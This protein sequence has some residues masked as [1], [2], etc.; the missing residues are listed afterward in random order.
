MCVPWIVPEQPAIGLHEEPVT[1]ELLDL[2]GQS[3]IG[4]GQF[5]AS[6][7]IRLTFWWL[8]PLKVSN[9]EHTRLFHADFY[10]NI[11]A[12]AVIDEA[13]K[14]GGLPTATERDFAFQWNPIGVDEGPSGSQQRRD[15]AI[16]LCRF[17]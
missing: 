14:T 15:A 3:W 16:A 9:A 12:I 11:L 13:N 8:I 7:N 2:A 6:L 1:L 10:G 4:F 5:N 17:S